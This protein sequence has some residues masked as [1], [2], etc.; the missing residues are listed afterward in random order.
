MLNSNT[1]HG[2]NPTVIAI[3]GGGF[4][5]CL[6]ATHL[7]KKVTQPLIIKLIERQKNVGQG[8]A[9]STQENTDLLN[10]PIGKMSAFVD[11]TDHFYHWVKNNYDDFKNLLPQ[12][13]E[14]SS[15]IP[16]KIYGLYLQSILAEA[17][18]KS[19]KNVIF[20][21]LNDEV[22]GI[23]S[24]EKNGIIY[25]RS[26][27]NFSADKIVLA[28]GNSAFISNVYHEPYLYSGWSGLALENLHPSA[29]ILLIGT[30]L[31]MADIVVALNN[32]HHQGKIYALSRRGLLPQSHQAVKPYPLFLT[33]ETAPNTIRGLT[34]LIRK[35]VKFAE[36][37][38][39]NWRSVIDSLRPVTQQLW[40]KL[41]KV[42]QKRF[43]RHVTPYWETHRHR[44]AQI[45]ADI[46]KEKLNSGQLIIETARVKEYK[47]KKDK[48]SVT[49]L[50][51][52]QDKQKVIL[53][54]RIINCTGISTDYQKSTNPLIIDLLKKGLIRLNILGLGIDTACDGAIIS[55]TGKTSKFLYT[56]GTLRKGDL[57]ETTAIA[58]LRQQVQLL[59]QKIAQF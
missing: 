29:D 31:T 45:I 28:L 15:F 41:P 33:I 43:L 2:S 7:L 21:R 6:I 17:E 54:D 25:L 59:A 27:S 47:V 53:V 13:L 26:G 10:V 57:W 30:G 37:Q 52:H 9:Y 18:V 23:T 4:C 46:V 5:G 20:Q 49:I 12:P 55:T 50:P 34:K 36:N 38:G 22:I 11:D 51:R 39:Y 35:E 56:I 8:I 16:R 14:T 44:V 42:E 3:V 24:A 58:E 1:F 32:R 48:V 19:H 40:Q